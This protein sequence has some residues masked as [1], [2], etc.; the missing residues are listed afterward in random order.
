MYS[1]IELTEDLVAQRFDEDDNLIENVIIPKGTKIR[2][3]DMGDCAE[4]LSPDEY[5]GLMFAEEDF[6]DCD[7]EIE[8]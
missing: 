1:E 8:L 5:K 4:I 6:D 7:E 2:I 3:L